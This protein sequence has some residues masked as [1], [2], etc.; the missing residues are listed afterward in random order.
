M[1]DRVFPS[2]KPTANGGTATP[3]FPATKAQLYGATTRSAYRPQPS[4]RRHRRG[5]CCRCCLWT[6]VAFLV[7]LLLIAAAAAIFYALY[8]PQRPSFSVTSFRLAYLN[9]TSSG[10]SSKFNLTVTAR[11]P[12]KKVVYIYSPTSI[13]VLASDV[14]VGDGKFPAF[15]HGKRNSTVLRSSITSNNQPLDSDSLSKLKSALKG[16]NGVPLK[17][18]LDTKVKMKAGGLKTPRIGIRVTCDG[19]RATVPA[20][21]KAPAVA[22][23][24]NV[25]CKVD[26]RIKIWKWTF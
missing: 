18:K 11:N 20:A 10:V 15:V 7:L 1:T 25:K 8:R 4:R 17:V 13:S 2:A 21:G 5:C 12:N 22:S 9:T 24:A 19:I 3:T 14:D 23:T 26:T 6:T 16:K